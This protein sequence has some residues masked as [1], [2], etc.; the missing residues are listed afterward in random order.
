[1]NRPRLAI[2]IVHQQILPEVYGRREV[3]LAAAKFGDLLNELHQAVVARSMK[4]LIR[5]PCFL[6]RPTSSRVLLITS[7][8]SPKA[9]R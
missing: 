1:M 8:S 7:G 3:R 2:H 4:V 6:Q 5:M 9:L